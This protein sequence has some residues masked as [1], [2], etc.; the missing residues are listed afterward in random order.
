MSST[1][2]LRLYDIF[3]KSFKLSEIEAQEA[4]QVIENVYKEQSFEKHKHT[5]ELIHKDMKVLRD[6]IDNKL[7]YLKDY[8]DTKFST[9]EEV[10]KISAN[11]AE[12]KAEIIKWSFVFWVGTV[13]TVLGGLFTILKL[14]F[15]K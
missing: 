2:S 4:V 5:E 15:D 9:K 8:M 1:A 10:V 11:I 14:F 6:H 7:G 13:V 3:R 12:T